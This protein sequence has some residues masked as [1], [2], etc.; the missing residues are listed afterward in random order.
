M[1]KIVQH[2]QMKKNKIKWK[3]VKKI[4]IFVEFKVPVR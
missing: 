3:I 4:C 1:K 2:G